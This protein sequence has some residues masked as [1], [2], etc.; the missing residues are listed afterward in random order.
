MTREEAKKLLMVISVAYPNYKPSAP[1][2]IVVD[3]W[4]NQLKDYPYA[5]VS[6]ALEDF[7]KSDT[8]G[9]APSIGQLIDAMSAKVH[10]NDMSE[11]EAWALVTKAVEKANY[12]ADEE[13][14]K[15]P[16]LVRRAV[17][18]PAALREYAM[19]DINDFQT[20]QKALFQRI[21]RG[22]TTTDRVMEKT[23][24]KLVE[25]IERS[26][27]RGAVTLSDDYETRYIGRAGL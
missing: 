20:V 22:L 11:A 10:Q 19:M 4:A 27:A 15:L 24:P 26:I 18:S 6:K 17:G 25:M 9:F 2:N 21:Y 23:S 14:K 12:Y 1:Q 7:I 5:V 16:E 3:V 8:K 13:F